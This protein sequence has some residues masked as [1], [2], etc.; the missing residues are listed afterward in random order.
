MRITLRAPRRLAAALVA[1]G[2]AAC[3]TAA[4]D[5][6]APAAVPGRTVDAATAGSIAGTIRFEG[7]PPP[8]EPIR[9]GSDPACA[10]QA[11]PS[12][13]SD[14]VLVSAD[15][16]LQNVFVY[17]K[18]GLDP[19][20]RFETPATPV[21]LDQQGCRYRPRVLGI[22]V[23]QP[24]E[25]ANGDLTFH[26]VHALPKT[27]AEFNHGLN[28]RGDRMTHTFDAP[29]VMVRFKCDVHGWMA[30]YMG[31]MAHPFFAVT[32][33]DGS[34]SLQGVPPGT[35]TVEAWHERFGTRTAT[36]TVAERQAQTIALAFAA[37]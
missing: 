32:G 31:V 28:T 24:L 7:A 35:Y 27:N 25:L 14:A 17:I 12:P 2:L 37:R 5:T 13:Q 18:D 30:A 33:A 4:P 15:G 3:G 21:V 34:F 29:E 9:M 19:G 26:N 16:G 22:R 10:E 20:Y 6:S 1:A 36:V 11:G 8:R 23:H